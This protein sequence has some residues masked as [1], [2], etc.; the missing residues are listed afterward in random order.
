MDAAQTDSSRRGNPFPTAPLVAGYLLLVWCGPLH[1]EI[2]KWTDAHGQVHYSDRPVAGARQLDTDDN[3][4]PDNTTRGLSEFERRRVE[5]F[6][7]DRAEAQRQRDKR[8]R[9]QEKQQ[10]I[11]AQRNARRCRQYTNLVD[12]YRARLRAGCRAT[13]CRE[14][15]QRV[16]EYRAEMDDY[17]A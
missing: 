3:P 14:Y 11:E 12:R 17:C 2:Y 6:D 15:K 1:A 7:R 8:R 4:L 13:Q 5:V 16:R 10:H 9:E